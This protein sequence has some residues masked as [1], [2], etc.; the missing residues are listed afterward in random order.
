MDFSVSTDKY[1]NIENEKIKEKL[2]ELNILYLNESLKGNKV[3]YLYADV[4][5][6]N[7]FSFN[8]NICFY[9]AS[10]I[11]IL[12]CLMLL[13]MAEKNE[14][15][16]EEKLLV[17]KEDLK[18]DTG[19]IKNQKE[20]TYYTINKLIEL[21]IVESDNTAYLKL[22]NYVGKNKLKEYGNSLGAVHTMEGKETDSFGIINCTDML[23]YWQK[24]REYIIGNKKYSKEFKRFLT[25]PSVR[26]IQNKNINNYE[27]VRKYGSWDIAYHEAG[28]V[29]EKNPYY[30]IILTQLNKFD[31]K[32]EFINKSAKL[33]SE[34]HELIQR[35]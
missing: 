14:V 16:L 12:V 2:R 24:V 30:L 1:M 35:K 26:F 4:K 18:Q 23:I 21:T 27:F 19:V 10:S 34:I 29:N 9:A 8:K 25:N 17:T 3:A 20:D 5:G 15:D 33:I 7:N 6:I 13:E 22:V 31:Y 32:E 28:Y 11:K